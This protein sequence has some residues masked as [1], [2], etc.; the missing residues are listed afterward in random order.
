QR[1]ASDK[2]D[3]PGNIQSRITKSGSTRFT[4]SCACSAVAASV[5]SYP[6]CRR[7]IA[8]SSAIADSSSTTSTLLIA[9]SFNHGLNDLRRAMSHVG[10]F[11]NVNN[12]FGQVRRVIA[13]AL[14]RFGHPN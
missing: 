11:D 10:T 5:M 6:A 1:F 8:S 9:D 13:D 12:Y 2:P 4:S 7:L 14:N 3:C